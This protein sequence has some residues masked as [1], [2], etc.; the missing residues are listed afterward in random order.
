[1]GL[2]EDIAEGFNTAR[3]IL[4][5]KFWSKLHK[6][7]PP[8]PPPLSKVS[9][10]NKIKLKTKVWNKDMDYSQAPFAKSTFETA[11]DPNLKNL[12]YTGATM[13]NRNIPKPPLMPEMKVLQP[14]E[15]K[16]PVKFRE[17]DTPLR[18]L[19]EPTR[20]M[21]IK[22]YVE[23]EILNVRGP[24]PPTVRTQLP[25]NLTMIK[26][27]FR[28]KDAPLRKLKEPTRSK[29][30]ADLIRGEQENIIPRKMDIEIKPI[31][32]DAPELKT[33][34]LTIMKKPVKFRATKD[35]PLRKLKEKT[36]MKDL[37]D[38][39]KGEQLNITPSMNI[40]QVQFETRVRKPKRKASVEIKRGRFRTFIP[41]SI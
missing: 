23:G 7:L 15:V 6:L 12:D 27:K 35:T 13:V 5:S 41:S 29:N 25:S 32:P 21:D 16:K 3:G 10:L 20:I 8:D 38:L 19:K 34:N 18:K 26:V 17:K 11:P 37:A 30:L 1:M 31:A 36:R 39:I 33:P 4:R 9:N 2:A 14:A 22:N 24:R 40:D 28:E